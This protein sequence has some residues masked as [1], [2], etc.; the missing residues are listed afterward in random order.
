MICVL[1]KLQLRESRELPWKCPPERCGWKR[2]VIRAEWRAVLFFQK[3]QTLKI[4]SQLTHKA[5]QKWGEKKRW[6]SIQGELHF[7]AVSRW[8]FFFVPQLGSR[9]SLFCGDPESVLIRAGGSPDCI[10]PGII[11]KKVRLRIAFAFH[12][13]TATDPPNVLGQSSLEMRRGEGSLFFFLMCV[14]YGACL[15]LNAC[16]EK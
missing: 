13:K 7:T 9:T 3:L 1:V 5:T 16:G 15:C 8:G 4:S 11:Q 6:T 12:G 2:V 14:S 10:H